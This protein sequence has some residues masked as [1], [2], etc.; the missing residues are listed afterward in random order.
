[1]RNPTEAYNVWT[2][3]TYHY[4]SNRPA[5]Q[6]WVEFCATNTAYFTDTVRRYVVNYDSVCTAFKRMA[7]VQTNTDCARDTVFTEE[8][9]VLNCARD[10]CAE[11]LAVTGSI[12]NAPQDKYRF[13]VQKNGVSVA[14]TLT[15]PNVSAEITFSGISKVGGVTIVGGTNFFYQEYD[16]AAAPY[17]DISASINV[18][19]GELFS[20]SSAFFSLDASCENESYFRC[21]PRSVN[22]GGAYA[23]LSLCGDSIDVAVSVRHSGNEYKDRTSIATF[24]RVLTPN[25][26]SFSNA[27]TAPASGTTGEAITIF[28]VPIDG[29]G[30]YIH[31]GFAEIVTT[32]AGGGTRTL[33]ANFRRNFFI[34][35]CAASCN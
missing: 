7:I 25:G 4:R 19:V 11:A 30:Q 3:Q 1:L 15:D 12:Q 22:D 29:E 32:T 16:C 18:E 14:P 20:T 27:P 5:G 23:D 31:E 34:K 6:R 17:Y 9:E 10:Y 26:R 35:F 21:E 13:F 2:G 28:R 33:R 8:R 24:G